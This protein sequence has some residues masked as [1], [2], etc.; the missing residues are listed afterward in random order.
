MSLFIYVTRNLVN[1]GGL[2]T[3]ILSGFQ[4]VAADTHEGSMCHGLLPGNVLC[5]L[6]LSKV[7]WAG[8]ALRLDDPFW[9]VWTGVF[10]LI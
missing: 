5:L 8:I 7:W 4:V 9:D 3:K 6:L 1:A 2:D 10:I